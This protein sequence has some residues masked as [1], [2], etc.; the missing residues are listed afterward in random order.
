MKSD[1]IRK[2]FIQFFEDRGHKKYPSSSLL[3]KDKD[4]ST[5]FTSAGMQQF[6]DWYTDYQKIEESRVVTC[7]DCFRTSDIEE[8]GDR[9]H[10][11]YFQMLGNFSFG[12]PKRESSYFKK[13]ALEMAWEFLTSEK[14]L[15]IDPEKITATIFAGDEEVPKDK[16]SKKLLN[17]IGVKKVDQLGRKENFW[18]PVGKTGPCGPT[19][20]FFVDHKGEQVEIWNLV[21]NQYYKKANSKLEE[22][23]FQGIDTGMGL[24]RIVAYMADKESDYQTDLFLPLMKY[25]GKEAEASKDDRESEE[26]F[27]IIADHIRGALFL[28]E[29]GVVP[30]N[31]EEGY[32]LRRILRRSFAQGQ[33][34]RL[35]S[36][37]WQKVI[38]I[39]YDR[40]KRR[41]GKQK[42]FD[43]KLSEVKRLILKERENFAQTLEEGI[44]EFEKIKG[45]FDEK[46]S[47]KA[48]FRLHDTYGLPKRVIEKLAQEEGL[49]VDE[50][51]YKKA[52]QKHKEVSRRGAGKFKGGLA[53]S[54]KETVKLHTAAHLLHQ[55]LR[56]VLGEHVKQAGQNITE[57]R[58]RF[59]FTH[60]KSMSEKEVEK[61]ER[62]VNDKIN[63]CL[64]VESR[65][66]ELDKALS[67]G[68]LALF[69]GKYPDKVT[70]YS[71]GDFSKELCL[72]PHVKNTGQL[73]RFKIIKE[74][75]S[76]KGV[77]R[78]RA[79]LED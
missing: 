78:I 63:K 79:V 2:K 3:P 48:A 72:G 52:A 49:Q 43:K 20:E 17:K 28:I 58:L 42:G 41:D 18:G 66:M 45:S 37:N 14:Y 60:P 47:G 53:D 5:L 26:S 27:R 15:N 7:Q 69:K 74:E 25:L 30:G 19:V 38:K 62:L 76:S 8:V 23:E 68:A 13:E 11:T 71:I 46:L 24:E 9:T 73:G 6:K 70:V 44:R 16:K 65:E 34:I 75:S 33:L 61:V 22:L 36:E 29:A 55:A 39:T 77:R 35:D 21:F 51:G 31:V 32:I 59:D 12:Y 4:G 64:S 50:K 40:Y 56:E 67:S 10:H 54:K 1:Q 57:E